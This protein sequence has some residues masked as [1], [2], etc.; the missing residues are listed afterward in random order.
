MGARPSMRRDAASVL[1]RD[2]HMAGTTLARGLSRDVLDPS[3]NPTARAVPAQP[4][5]ATDSVNAWADPPGPNRTMSTGAVAVGI[6]VPGRW[7]VG[8]DVRLNAPGGEIATPVILYATI[9]SELD[10]NLT[11]TRIVSAPITLG[12]ELGFTR[13]VS[14]RPGEL[15]V[16][17]TLEAD[18]PDDDWPEPP[19]VLLVAT[20]DRIT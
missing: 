15:A 4:V 1:G 14:A 20:A 16:S 2:L 12:L 3:R 8:L 5:E 7:L 17:A 18:D 9:G 10:G 13:L 6:G 19:E 11:E